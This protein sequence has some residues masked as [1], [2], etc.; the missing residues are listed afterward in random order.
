[1]AQLRIQHQEQVDELIEDRSKW[2]DAYETAFRDNT[3][4]IISKEKK[5]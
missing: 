3:F 2:Y 5:Y 4:T 1:M